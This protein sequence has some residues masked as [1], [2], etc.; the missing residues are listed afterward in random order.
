MEVV[1][2][3]GYAAAY[4]DVIEDKYIKQFC[5]KEFEAFTG[6]VDGCELDLDEFA[7]NAEYNFLDGYDKDLVKAYE[8]LCE[9]FKK[10]TGL[11]I[12]LAYHD[13]G[14]EGDRYDDIDGIY[15]WVNG[16][17]ELTK[18][19]KKMEKFVERKTFVQ[20]G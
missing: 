14:D 16:M 11:E 7:R 13:S 3:M 12:G 9:A 8:N 1:M 20:F 10:E 6:I 18:A 17:Y 4:A 19:G 2:G 5:P 15:W